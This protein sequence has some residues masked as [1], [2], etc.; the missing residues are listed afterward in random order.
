MS[1]LSDLAAI[2][3]NANELLAIASA[4]QQQQELPPL[5]LPA[6]GAVS[7]GSSSS[8]PQQLLARLAPA[9]A[10]VL[11]QGE[12]VAHLFAALSAR[13][14]AQLSAQLHTPA[15]LHPAPLTSPSQQ[16]LQP[17]ESCRD[18]AAHP[19]WVVQG[20]KQGERGAPVGQI[21]G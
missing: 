10:V 19:A 11:Q 17:Q 7:E 6:A 5:Q 1:F 21:V 9:A 3:P 16:S 15:G 13:L 4:V 14:S 20:A 8:S 12:L 18:T 2:T